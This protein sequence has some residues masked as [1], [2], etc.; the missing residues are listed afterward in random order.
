MGSWQMA[1]TAPA[2]GA[3]EAPAATG[4]ATAA[5]GC[6]AP[7]VNVVPQPWHLA[8]RPHWSSLTWYR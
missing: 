7:I 5:A 6:A 1:H 4:A 3:L 2:P 8:E